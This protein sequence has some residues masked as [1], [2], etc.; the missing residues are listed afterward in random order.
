M[1]GIL[2]RKDCQ[3]LSIVKVRMY[4][5]IAF[6]CSRH[7]KEIE[8][9]DKAVVERKA[10]YRIC[11]HCFKDIIPKR[12]KL[13]PGLLRYYE[14]GDIEYSLEAIRIMFNNNVQITVEF[15]K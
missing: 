13:Q 2:H 8:L 1:T 5:D 14:S 7:N 9:V 11:N 6:I 15:S 10:Y 4:Q 12:F 3:F